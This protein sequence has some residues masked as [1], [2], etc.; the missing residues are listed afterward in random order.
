MTRYSDH[1]T[2][3]IRMNKE[4]WDKDKNEYVTLANETV[5]QATAL[6]T[7]PRTRSPTSSTAGSTSTSRTTSTIRWPGRTTASRARSEY[8]QLLYIPK[9][10]P[11]DLWDRER[12]HGIKLYVRRVFIM[13]DAEQ[14]LPG[15]LRFSRA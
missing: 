12:A 6:W 2:M 1:I 14:L 3:P 7:R 15:Y 5:N 10:A 13:D 11:F 8:I 9:R 4:E